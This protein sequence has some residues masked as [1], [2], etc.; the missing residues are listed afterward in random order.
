MDA[1]QQIQNRGA[2]RS[3]LL[4]DAAKLAD[5]LHFFN[6][7]NFIDQ[8]RAARFAQ[9]GFHQ[10]AAFL[11]DLFAWSSDFPS[12]RA[13]SVT[14]SDSTVPSFRVISTI[15]CLAGS[16]LLEFFARN[17]M[18]FGAHAQYGR[19]LHAGLV[20][21]GLERRGLI[22]DHHGRPCAA[23]RYP[24]SRDYR[25]RALR[26][27]QAARRPTSPRRGSRDAFSECCRWRSS[28]AWIGEPTVHFLILVRAIS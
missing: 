4:Q 2:A 21:R 26:C 25:R 16:M 18:H 19:V 22:E 5:V 24:A 23:G 17:E 12:C 11:D 3:G 27:W 10:V 28:G 14:W 20:V 8:G 7:Q 1:C 15:A 6:P 9:D 13:P